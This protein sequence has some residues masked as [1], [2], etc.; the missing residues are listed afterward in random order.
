M[1]NSH[2]L[3]QRKYDAAN[4][5]YFYLKYNV[6]T[7]KEIIKKLESVPSTQ[8]Y[9]RQLIKKDLAETATNKKEDQQ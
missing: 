6:T 4:C 8:G 9:I 1:A 5:R 7:D 3:A 2:T